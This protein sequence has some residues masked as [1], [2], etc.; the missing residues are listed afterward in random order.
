[1]AWSG[2]PGHAGQSMPTG[3]QAPVSSRVGEGSGGVSPAGVPG[4]GGASDAAGAAS[5]DGAAA[6]ADY[7]SEVSA[8]PVIRRNVRPDRRRSSTATSN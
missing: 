1:M 2:W 5:D 7:S 6:G 8:A 3:G 4:S